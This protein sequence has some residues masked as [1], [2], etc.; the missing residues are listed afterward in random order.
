MDIQKRSAGFGAA[1]LIFAVLFRLVMGSLTAAA[2]ATPPSVELPLRLP[3]VAF[4]PLLPTVQPT[5]PTTPTLPTE[6]APPVTT[7]PPETNVPP[8]SKITF[9]AADGAYLRLRSATDCPYSPDL[10]PLLLQ[11]LDW[12]LATGEPTVLIYHSHAC[13][14]YAKQDQAYTE[15]APGRTTDPNYNMVAVGD[16]LASLLESRG[17]SVIH[18]RQLHDALSYNSAYTNSA[19]SVSEYLRQYPSIRLVLDLH[20]DAATAT[21]GSAYATAVEINGETA[22]QFMFVIGTD[23]NGSLHQNWQ[24]NLGLACKLQVLLEKQV[25]GITRRSTL[26]GCPFNQNLSTGALLIE[27]GASGNTLQQVYRSLPYLAN[28]IAALAY[29]TEGM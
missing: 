19:H 18:D 7:A 25:P 4:T 27:V 3:A 1:L 20:R 22:A 11:P 21:D 23:A 9:S 26:R 13:E 6:T 8:P 28:A 2:Q 14:S 17:I 5:S 29:G 16:A 15:Q 24:K 12:Q 10:L